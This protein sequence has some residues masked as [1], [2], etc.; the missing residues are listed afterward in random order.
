MVEPPGPVDD[1]GH[2]FANFHRLFDSVDNDAIL[3]VDAGTPRRSACVVGRLAA[4]H[5]VEGGCGPRHQKSAFSGSQVR[6][7]GI[8][9]LHKG[10]GV[11]SFSVS[12]GKL[13]FVTGW[14]KEFQTGAMARSP[15]TAERV[16]KK[17]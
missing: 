4:A 15:S 12:C 3:F 14:M 7:V 1:T 16:A 17:P 13:P 9:R 2:V 8:E 10:F 5:G 11:V 6:T